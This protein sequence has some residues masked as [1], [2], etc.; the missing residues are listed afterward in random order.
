MKCKNCEANLV[1][2][3]KVILHRI[4]PMGVIG[5]WICQECLEDVEQ[6]NGKLHF[7]HSKTCEGFCDYSCNRAGFDLAK[8]IENNFK[9]YSS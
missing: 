9:Y 1:I 5:E 4:N 2:D 7:V 8:Q 3:T 6:F